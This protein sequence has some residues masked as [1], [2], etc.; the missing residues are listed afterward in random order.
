MNSEIHP[1][2]KVNAPKFSYERKLW[3]RGFKL[4][5]GTDEVGRGCFAGPVVAACVVFDKAKHSRFFIPS[6]ININDSK[7]LTSRQREIADKWIQ[8]NSVMFGIGEVSAATINR[9][10]MAKATK[11]AFRKAVS[12]ANYRSKERVEYLLI[13]AFYIPYIRGI[14]M[15]NKTAR[16]NHKLRDGRARQRAIVN[17]DEK[18]MSIA[19]ASIVAKVYRDNLMQKI[20]KRARYRKYDWLNNKGYATKKHQNAILKYGITGYHR[21]Q[22]VDTFLKNRGLKAQ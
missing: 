4:V 18:V 8:E 5:A 1:D 16:R 7:K 9:I 14:P 10:G 6:T 20:G 12:D 2:M 3:K 15:R 19:A 13:D 21:K 22:F 17:G 11:M